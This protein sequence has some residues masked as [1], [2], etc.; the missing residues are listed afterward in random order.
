VSEQAGLP[1]S[2]RSRLPLLLADPSPCLRL[3][4][5]R[6]LLNRGADDVE[7]QELC[8]LRGQDPLVASL[9]AVQAPNGSW[10]ADGALWQ[11]SPLRATWLALMRLGYLGFGPA[12]PAVCRGAD[13]LFAR[14][15]ADGAWPIPGDG[16]EVEG[17]SMV[18]LQTA[19]PLRALAACGY[20][21]DPRAERAYDWLLAQRLPDG[22]WPT[23]IAGR[24]TH[25]RRSGAVADRDGVYGYVAGYRRLAHSRWGC[26][27]NTTGSLICLALH[28]VRRRGPEARR[29]LDLLLGRETRERQPVGYEVART[30]GAEPARGFLTFFARFDLALL[31]DLCWR[32]GATL[33]DLRVAELVEHVWSLRGAY[34]LWEYIPRPQASR[35]VSFDL[36]RSLSRLHETGDWLSAEPWTPFRPIPYPASEGQQAGSISGTRGHRF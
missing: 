28:P 11:G 4:A 35:W 3:L 34:G 5:L 6:E 22:A 10:K 15:R 23:G 13:Y 8:R 24:S 19:L 1:S 26:R 17:Y 12:H 31:L 30:I 29:A 14:Q 27:S 18:P 33:E 21:T 7:V 25:S 20:A 32:V 36:Y 16:G 2:S 9:L